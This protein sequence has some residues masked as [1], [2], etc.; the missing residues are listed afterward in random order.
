M[1]VGRIVGSIWCIA[2]RFRAAG[3]HLFV[4]DLIFKMAVRTMRGEDAFV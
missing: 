2:L 4:L 1:L 3:L